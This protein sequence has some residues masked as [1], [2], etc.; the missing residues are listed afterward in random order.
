GEIR[1]KMIEANLVDC[2]VTL[3]G[4]LFSTTQ[5]AVCLWFLTRDK[6][7]GLSRDKKLRDRTGEILF[8]DARSLGTMA[9]RTLKELT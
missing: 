8:I 5:I 3:P 4:Q 1:R 9:S 2:I 7:N 6:S